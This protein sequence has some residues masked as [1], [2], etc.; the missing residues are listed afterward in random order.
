MAV[1][2][3]SGERSSNRRSTRK[4]RLLGPS[5]TIGSVRA[6]PYRLSILAH[7]LRHALE[8]KNLLIRLITHQVDVLEVLQVE[9]VHA[10]PFVRLFILVG[11]RDRNGVACRP[12]LL[13]MLPRAYAL[14]PAWILRTSV[15]FVK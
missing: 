15:V 13:G 10:L 2:R 4:E 11:S 3:E 5:R 1:L 14:N 6:L 8:V 12:V 9:V 7:D